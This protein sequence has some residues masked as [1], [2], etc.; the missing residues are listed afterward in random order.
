MNFFSAKT[1]NI[2]HDVRWLLIL[3]VVSAGV[4]GTAIVLSRM[5]HE[6][7]AAITTS[8]GLIWALVFIISEL[9]FVCYDILLRKEPSSRIMLPGFA[10]TAAAIVPVVSALTMP[11][12]KAALTCQ[13]LISS[14]IN[15]LIAVVVAFVL[16]LLFENLR[17]SVF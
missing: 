13:V 3:L 4:L 12:W 6:F 7:A 10:G 14:S 16:S 5:G 2:R 17:R 15:L 8:V 9:T 1:T 11:D